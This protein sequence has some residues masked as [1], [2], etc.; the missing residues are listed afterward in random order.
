MVLP[1]HRFVFRTDVNSYYASISHQRLMA[2]LALQ[3]QDPCLLDVVAQCLTRTA[4]RGGVFW[5]HT[6][7]IPLACSLSPLRAVSTYPVCMWP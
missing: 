1:S 5:D 7:G 2:D 4:E 6:R 3:V